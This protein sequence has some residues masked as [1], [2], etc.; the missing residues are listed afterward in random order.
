MQ[1]IDISLST[2]TQS[3]DIGL[4]QITQSVGIDVETSG[5]A[6]VHHDE[7]LKGEGTTALPLGIADDVMAKI[8]TFTFEQ[9]IAADVWVIE[10]N[11]D[12]YPSVSVVDSANNI[13]SGNVHYIDENNLTI[14]F[15][16]AFTGKAFLN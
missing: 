13:V 2:E 6:A 1:E 15:N 16:G 4:S 9:G 3:L 8:E 7:T 11:L 10:H 12:K 5:L 14:T